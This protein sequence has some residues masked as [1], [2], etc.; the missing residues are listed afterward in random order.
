LEP[1]WWRG[2]LAVYAGKESLPLINHA[3]QCEFLSAFAGISRQLLSTRL[4]LNQEADR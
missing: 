1:R 4:V 3:I 2:G